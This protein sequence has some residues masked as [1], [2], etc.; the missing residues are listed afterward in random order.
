[1][2]ELIM[3]REAA[4]Y[5]RRAAM[6]PVWSA[7]LA[8]GAKSFQDNPVIGS[9]TLNNWGLHAARLRLAHGLAAS[10]R[11]RLSRLVSAEDRAAFDRDG[12]IEKRDFLPPD[13]FARVL[14]EV[15]AH[16][17]HA[18]ETVQG[19]A[20][21]RRIALD[22]TNLARLPALAAMLRTPQWRGLLRYAGSYDAEP[23][24][25]LQTILSHAEVGPDDP[26]CDLHSDTFQ[27]SVKAWLFLTD[28]A[29]DEGPFTFVPG[30]H[31]LTPQRLDWEHRQSLR[32][33][34]EPNRLTRRGSFRV[35]PGEL[36]AM[37]LP[38]ARA[39]AVPANTL[40]VA[41]TY[42]FH[43]RAPSPRPTMRVE[44]WSFGRRNPFLPWTGMDLWKF[45]ALGAR[46]A[47]L[48]WWGKDLIERRG[49]LINF[50]RPKEGVGAF[51]PAS[52]D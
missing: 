48:I 22:P 18:R 12:F 37:G 28:V 32:M 41:D 5:A 6:L 15:K 35:K 47:P 25:Y 20:V 43:A 33:A 50:W 16:R 29:A 51:D 9:P 34:E 1:M 42:G 49:G 31:R 17:G 36:A 8:T 3:L 11:R 39:F 24:H 19:N 2:K 10:R 38:Q 52:P 7:Q 44:V 4:R 30:S 26:Q 46:R 14:E 40:V 45:E 23:I 13:V 21:T 27:P